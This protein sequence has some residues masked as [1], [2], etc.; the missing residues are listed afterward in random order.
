M[1]NVMPTT[2]WGLP[3]NRTRRGWVRKIIRPVA[4]W[5][6][7]RETSATPWHCVKTTSTQ[8]SGRTT[9]KGGAAVD[10]MLVIRPKMF[11]RRRLFGSV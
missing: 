1:R 8:N 7:L 4:F 11:T 10:R 6:I 2:S 5:I 3:V 9:G